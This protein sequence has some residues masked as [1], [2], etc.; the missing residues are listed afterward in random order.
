MHA[1]QAPAVW[2]ELTVSPA[3]LD[4]TIRDQYGSRRAFARSVKSEMEKPK[5]R[6]GFNG[7]CSH[8]LINQLTT[9]TTRNT[10]PNL[11]RAME[12]LLNRRGR[13]RLACGVVR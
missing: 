4:Q 11:A 8:A 12:E 7:G 5:Y 13:R 6:R 9:G 2:S 1:Q 10:H 3:F